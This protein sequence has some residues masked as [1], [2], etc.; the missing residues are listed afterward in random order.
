L[1]PFYVG[2]LGFV[3]LRGD[4]MRIDSNHPSLTSTPVSVSG[5]EPARRLIVLVPD[6]DWDFLP[7]K[8]RIRELASAWHARV[9]LL[10]L[11]NDTRQELS[12]RRALVTMSA[13]AENGRGPV[14]TNVEIGLNWM[15]AV[16][17][18]YLTGDIIVCFAEQRAGLLQKPLSQILESNLNVP[19]YIISGLYLQKPRS[20]WF[21]QAIIWFGF[22]GIILGFCMLQIRIIQLPPDWFQNVLLILS[23]FPEFWLIWAWNH[24]FG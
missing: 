7:V 1:S 14:Q 11:C 19:L 5:P 16:K 15:D 13:M 10:A 4:M 18:N 3:Y 22:I 17:R 6:A 9:L 20:N 24:L 8:Q 12:L 23:I 2:L 21:S